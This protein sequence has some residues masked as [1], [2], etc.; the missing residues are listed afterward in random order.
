MKNKLL[1][2]AALAS[3][4]LF[5]AND[6][7]AQENGNRDENGKIVR[8]PY[9]TNTFGSNWFVGVGGGIGLS[10]D[11]GYKTRVAPA[12]DIQVGKWFTPSVGARIGYQGLTLNEWA[13]RQGA[14]TTDFNAD[15]NMW[16]RKQGF[17]YIH[18]DAMWNISNAIGGYKETRFW[19]VI[20]YAHGGIYLGYGVKGKKV[21]VDRELAGGLGIYNTMRLTNRVKLSLDVRG[22]LYNGRGHE[23]TGGLAGLFSTTVGVVVNLGKTNFNR[24][25]VVPAGYS[26]YNVAEIEKLNESS[27]QLKDDNKALAEKNAQLT[28]ANEALQAENKSLRDELEALKAKGVCVTPGAVFFNIG[29][30]TLDERE[31]FHLDFYVKTCIE[32]DANKVFQLTGYADK[33]TGTKKRNQYLSEKRVEYVYNLLMTRYNIPAERLVVKAAGCEVDRLNSP[34]LNRSVVLE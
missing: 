2:G 33:Q 11:G 10:V 28:Q 26:T 19:D 14:L 12:L 24:A 25:T 30:T 32:Q 7:F 29:Q 17:A 9:E 22:T 6:V 21:G 4:M 20:P 18:A 3:L 15:K 5:A 1:F 8:G 23:G 16:K 31:L 13:S 27:S 34:I